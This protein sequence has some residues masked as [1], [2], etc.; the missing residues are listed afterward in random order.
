MAVHD[1]FRTEPA[2]PTAVN[3][4]V[5]RADLMEAVADD[6]AGQTRAAK[7]RAAANALAASADDRARVR[8][9]KITQIA[10]DAVSAA[11]EATRAAEDAA[12]AAN[13]CKRR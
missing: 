7:A 12:K 5:R 4:S 9:E 6:D 2:F 11:A 3:D 8:G 13:D 1:R 10:Q